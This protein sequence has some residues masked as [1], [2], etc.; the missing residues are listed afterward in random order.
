MFKVPIKGL[1]FRFITYVNNFNKHLVPFLVI[2]LC[3]F[4]WV[5]DKI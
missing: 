5:I 4:F 1:N 2:H 3:L